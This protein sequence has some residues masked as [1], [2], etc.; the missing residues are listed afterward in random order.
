MGNKVLSVV[1]PAYNMEKY[2]KQTLDSLI[3]DEYMD[4]LEVSKALECIFDLLRECNKYIDD[5]M[6]WVL[7]KDE[8]KKDRLATVIYNLVECILSLIHI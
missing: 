8:D 1:I 7:Y 4:K 5:T 2:I 3:C 6:P